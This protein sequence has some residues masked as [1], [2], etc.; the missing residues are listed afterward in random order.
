MLERFSKAFEILYADLQRL[1]VD[2]VRAL[3]NLVAALLVLA[4][5]FFVARALRRWIGRLILRRTDNAAVGRIMSGIVFSMVLAF[6][7]FLALGV[8]N[9]DKTVSSLLAGAGILGLAFGLAMKDI[10]SNYIAGILLAIQQP[11]VVGDLVKLHDQFGRVLELNLKN[12]LLRSPQGQHIFIPNTK[13]FG[14]VLVNY[15]SSGLRRVE[16]NVGV[17]Y[18]EDL[19]KVRA[20]AKSALEGLP[21]LADFPVEVYFLEFADSA[22]NLVARCWIRYP[23]PT[24]FFM[25]QSEAIIAIKAAFDKAGIAIPFPIRTLDF[26]IQGG[27]TLAQSLEVSRSAGA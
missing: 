7:L 27:T 20:V 4:L 16:V 13:V 11:F 6:G 18:A 25:A 2:A 23:E 8:L 1:L 5:F 10:A 26:G 24:D 14:E 17:S 19:E 9:L 3:P 15:S 12:T 22:I 21:F